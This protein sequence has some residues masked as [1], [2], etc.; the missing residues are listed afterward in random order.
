[1]FCNYFTSSS[2]LL[3]SSKESFEIDC[4][5]LDKDLFAFDNFGLSKGRFTVL[6]ADLFAESYFLLKTF[7]YEDIDSL[8]F[9]IASS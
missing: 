6:S 2:I 3:L 7:T 8:V 5:S 9:A 4:L 1:V